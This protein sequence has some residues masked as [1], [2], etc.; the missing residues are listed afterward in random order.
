MKSEDKARYVEEEM[1]KAEEEEQ[2]HLNAEKE[3]RLVYDSRQHA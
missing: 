3:A 2:S 1:L